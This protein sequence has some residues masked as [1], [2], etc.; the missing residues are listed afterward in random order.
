V[1]TRQPIIEIGETVE[2]RYRISSVLGEGGMGTVYRAEHMLLK[3]SVAIKVLRRELAANPD[4]VQRFMKEARA[5]GTL[6]H[7][8]IVEATDMGF[9]G[10]K[11][12]YIVFE[13][14]EGDLLVD[15]IYKQRGLPVRRVLRIAHQIA[16]ALHA[17]HSAGIVHRDLKS[18]N[19]F[20]T[21]REA[22]DHVKVLDFGI[23]RFIDAD[24]DSSSGL[25]VMGTP[26]FMAP[27][28]ATNPELVDHRADIYAL[29][30]IMYEMITAQRPFRMTNDVESV[31]VRLVS[32]PP[33]PLV[34]SGGPPGLAE[35][36][37]DKLLAKDPEQRFQRMRDVADALEVM[38]NAQR[39]GSGINTPLSIAIPEAPVEAAQRW[40]WA[41][42]AGGIAAL[43]LGTAIATVRAAGTPPAPPATAPPSPPDRTAEIRAAADQLA[44]AIEGGVR[45]AHARADELASAAMLRAA[46]AKAAP[47]IRDVAQNEALFRPQ[48][49][50]VLEIFQLRQGAL[51]PVTH[52]PDR[53]RPMPPVDGDGTRLETDGVAVTIVA[54]APIAKADGSRAG[55]LAFATRLDLSAIQASLTRDALAARLRGLAR[56]VALVGREP[57]GATTT[58]PLAIDR[59]IVAEQLA[60]EVV[61]A[62]PAAAPAV[63]A[64]VS[65]EGRGL[66]IAPFACW[67]LGLVVL[68]VP[69]VGLL[70]KKRT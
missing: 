14:L 28:Q 53:A 54:G 43:A 69:A 41:W 7:P 2:G 49:D 57:S 13:Y 24:F 60:L 40:R 29:G 46:V 6:G 48:G 45:A 20:L 52:I 37:V 15:A 38:Y 68:G 58:I 61:V 31:L 30:V 3:R 16:S 67:G 35:L 62:A 33:P 19:I 1:S 18:E 27:E 11:L 66:G 4:A 65:D 50:E 21:R 25:M 23:S 42:L 51:H 5:A 12:P 70:R 44:K 32:E 9:L 55:A 26:E 34:I 10:D 64:P 8:H 56:P 47:A 36:I 17:A 39:T 22:G 63:I 59:A